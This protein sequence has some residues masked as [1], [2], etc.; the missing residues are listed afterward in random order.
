MIKRLI[1]YLVNFLTLG[2]ITPFPAGMTS[3]GSANFGLLEFWANANTYA[4]TLSRVTTAGTNSTLTGAQAV[5]G[6][7]ILAAGATGGFTITLPSTAAILSAMGGINTIPTDG[8]FSC[9]IDIKNNAVGQTGTLTAGDSSTTITG[10]ATIATNTTRTFLLTV[11]SA[12][13]VTYENMGTKNL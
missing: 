12:T 10:T 1:N 5:A 8:S 2:T 7:L 4:Q 9:L 11:T 13:T 6:A 3:D